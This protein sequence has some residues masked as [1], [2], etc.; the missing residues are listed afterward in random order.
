MTVLSRQWILLGLF[1]AYPTVMLVV[2]M[3]NGPGISIDSVS[4]AA[5]SQSWAESWE[6]LT[7]NG[8]PLTI[9]PPG[10]S[11]LAGTLMRLGLGFAPAIVAV[12]LVAT[13]ILILSAFALGKMVLRTSGWALCVAAVTALAAS[14]LRVNSYFWTEPVFTALIAVVLVILA[15]GVVSRV[16]TW[17]YVICLGILISVATMFRF[18]GVVVVPLAVFV[19]AWRSGANRLWKAGA[20][21][22]LSMVGF[23]VAVARNL[24]LGVPALGERY[25]GSVGVEGAIAGLVRLWGEYVAPSQTTSL[26]VIAGAGIAVLLIAGAWNVVTRRNEPGVV[27][28]LFVGGYWFAILVSQVGTRLDS[29]SERFGAPVFVATV[30][31]ILVAVRMIMSGAARQLTESGFLSA[32]AA[33]IGVHGTAIAV[34]A[35]IGS[36][37]VM[38]AVQY[39]IG[40]KRDGLGLDSATAM[41]RDISRAALKVPSEMVVASNDPWQVW[42]ARASGVVLDYPPSPAEW[43]AERVERDLGRL[44]DSVD[45]YGTVLLLIDSDAG[46]SLDTGTLR[47]IGLLAV[48]SGVDGSVARYEVIALY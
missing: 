11:L 27:L 12:N 14:T 17:P 4:Y 41:S 45:S 5:A 26:T 30:V 40:G 32:S 35:L 22:A 16:I 8:T 6:L 24:L 36:L 23:A 1:V 21:C 39:A 18:V 2:A 38:H 7:Y 37:S 19:V 42:W 44:A 43:P 15:R 28:V 13:V 20:A 33:R 34:V 48:P 10:L 31:L 9:F 46:A 25:P 29:A 47:D 3:S